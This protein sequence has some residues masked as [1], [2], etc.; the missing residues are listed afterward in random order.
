MRTDLDKLQGSWNVSALKLDGQSLAAAALAGATI[1]VEANRFTSLGM[2]GTYEGTL[3]IDQTRKP[4]AIDMVFTAGHA[5]G[6]RHQG[7]YKIQADRWTVCMSTQGERRPTLFASSKGSG[8]ALEVL[9]RTEGTTPK[10]PEEG[11]GPLKAAAS[12]VDGEWAAEDDTPHGSPTDWE[13]EWT[14]VSAVFN[15]GAMSQEMVKWCRRMTRGDI[16][17][18][19]AGPQVMLKARFRLD[20]STNPCSVEYLNLAGTHARK[21]QAGIFERRGTLLKVCM[22]PPKKPRPTEF[23]STSGDGHSYTVWRLEKE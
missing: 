15:G 10:E 14:M 6:T 4:R 5:A 17:T 18:V 16:T 3:K 22:A 20:G 1:L 12:G 23:S 13:G 9:T 7:I 11:R 21:P 2:G 8:F 19:V